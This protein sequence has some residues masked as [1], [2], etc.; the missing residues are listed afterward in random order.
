MHPDSED[1]TT[2]IT[3]FGT[4]KYRVMPFGLTNGPASYQHYMN[5]V[6]FE[7]LN[8]FCQAYL[9]DIIIYSKTR[10]EH[11]QYVRKV[12]QKLR[13]AGLQ[14]DI[15]KCEFHVQETAFL[16]LLVST[17]G[18]RMDP[19]KVQ[20]V[21]DWAKPTALKQVQAFVGFCNFYRRFI[22]D[23]SKI[24][25]PMTQLT[26]K[27]VPF[28]W[29]EACQKAFD[30]LKKQV[31]EAPV[32]KH[33]DREREA[34]LEADS[35]DYV[36]GGVLSQYDDQGVLHPVAFYSKNMVP[37]ECNYE[38]Y[39]KELLAIIRCLEHW[40]P[41]LECTEIPIK[42][43]TDHKSL[44]YF[45][46]SKELSRRQARWAEKLSE[47]NFKVIYRSGK[48]NEK[49]DAL[50][51]RADSAPK[52]DEDERR[53]Y[54]HRTLL[55]PD[56]VE[57]ADL[58]EADPDEPLYTRVIRLNKADEFCGEVRKALTEGKTI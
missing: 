54:Q 45:M 53:K 12:L 35:S 17:E 6:L 18:L 27:D 44:E 42:I 56:R 4:Y 25:R 16:G 48:Q 50:T 22:K 40:R 51:R 14:A 33:F 8:Q 1:L 46:T 34:I 26:Q 58:E 28:E 10:K 24:V 7:Y 13:E 36:N 55:T 3:S 57:V 49:A 43:F 11:V 47:Y 20:A 5:D 30:T 19:K 23:F 2:F 15:F 52:N 9:D 41:E 38:I 29:T 21:L 31:T 39:D 37:A 32:L